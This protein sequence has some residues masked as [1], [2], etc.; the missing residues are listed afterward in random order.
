MRM[1]S[2]AIVLIMIA[3][4]CSNKMF[5]N[6]AK[7]IPEDFHPAST[8]LLIIR[9][10]NEKEYQAAQ[11]FMK[12]NYP[13]PYEFTY[14]LDT[15]KFDAKKYRYMIQDIHVSMSHTRPV[16]GIDYYFYDRIEAREYPPTKRAS[17]TY[18]MT[19]RPFIRTIAVKQ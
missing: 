7:W 3:A 6:G 8:T 17:S 16:T 2:C 10:G 14:T 19:F 5:S 11:Q 4:G 9:F 12:E 1:V 18:L 15:A 13:Y